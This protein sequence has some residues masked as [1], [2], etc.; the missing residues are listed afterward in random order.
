MRYRQKQADSEYS[1]QLLIQIVQKHL[2]YEDIS[3]EL[4]VLMRWTR[5]TSRSKDHLLQKIKYLHDNFRKK[6]KITHVEGALWESEEVT[7]VHKCVRSIQ[8][9]F[10]TFKIR[11][12]WRKRRKI[13]VIFWLLKNVYRIEQEELQILVLEF[14]SFKLRWC[15]ARDLF[16]SQIPVTT[17]GFELTIFLISSTKHPNLESHV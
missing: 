17:R 4:I 3:I 10:E 11:L 2:R 16:G 1:R 13:Q 9:F 6:L 14:I 8:F 7:E 5:Q 15:R 12:F